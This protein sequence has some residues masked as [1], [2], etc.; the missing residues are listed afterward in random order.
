MIDIVAASLIVAVFVKGRNHF[1]DP[2]INASL[3]VKASGLA[4]GSVGCLLFASFGFCCATCG[5][6]RRNRNIT[7]DGTT[8]GTRTRRFWGRKDRS[9]VKA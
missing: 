6:G 8:Y 9:N 5:P 1:Q 3:G 2:R 4:W 7:Y